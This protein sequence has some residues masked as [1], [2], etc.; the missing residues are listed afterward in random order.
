MISMQNSLN[1]LHTD[2]NAIMNK[3]IDEEEF[4]TIETQL[5]QSTDKES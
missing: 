3:Y 5:N 2:V 4:T 1:T